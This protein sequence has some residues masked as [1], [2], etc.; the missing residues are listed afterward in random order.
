MFKK[1]AIIT[2]SILAGIAII[3]AIFFYLTGGPNPEKANDLTLQTAY[4]AK[5]TES[6]ARCYNSV[7]YG[8]SLI[9]DVRLKILSENFNDDSINSD[10]L[11]I[12]EK[13]FMDT[14]VSPKCEKTIADYETAYEAAVADSDELEGHEVWNFFFGATLSQPTTRDL[15][16]FQSSRARMSIAFN[17]YV[18]T[19]QEVKDYFDQHLDL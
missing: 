12:I 19:E 13:S 2:V 6:Y 8:T 1:I 16:G 7:N 18:F 14:V 17:D 11:D 4:M 3:G 9:G 15:S 5:S 10:R